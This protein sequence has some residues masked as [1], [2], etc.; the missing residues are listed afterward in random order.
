M[1]KK[2]WNKAVIATETQNI[3]V[4]P[5]ENFD[6]IMVEAKELDE[7]KSGVLYLNKDEMDLLILKLQEM[8]K[9]V[10]EK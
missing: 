10:L 6:G 5:T 9:Y 1:K 2:I 7:K 8:M 3:E 4:Y